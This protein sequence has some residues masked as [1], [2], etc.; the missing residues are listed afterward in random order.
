M[1]EH[2]SWSSWRY[3]HQ[4]IRSEWFSHRD[5]GPVWHVW[6]KTAAESM[7]MLTS[8]AEITSSL[9]T[10]TKIKIEIKLKMFPIKPAKLITF[11]IGDTVLT[12]WVYWWSTVKLVLQLVQHKSAGI[13]FWKFTLVFSAGHFLMSAGVY[14]AGRVTGSHFCLTVWKA[15]GFHFNFLCNEILLSS[16]K[17]LPL[18]LLTLSFKVNLKKICL[19]HEI[20]DQIFCIKKMKPVFCIIFFFM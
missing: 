1:Y 5:C 19:G 10:K 14:E 15:G 7:F 12:A 16:E 2:N 9:L 3:I 4:K 18:K 20:H 6:A 11:F 13:S 8:S 17:N